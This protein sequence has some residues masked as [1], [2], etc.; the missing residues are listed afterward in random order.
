[1]EKNNKT[2]LTAKK[3]KMIK[4][5]AA[6]VIFVI[7][8]VVAWQVLYNSGTFLKS[9]FPSIP[10]IF[11]ALAKDFTSD[12]HNL[13]MMVLNSMKL[14][15]Q[16][17]GIG[18]A[19]ALVLSGLSMASETVYSVYNMVVS[20]FD[21][22]P[23]VALL[24][25]AILFLGIGQNAI[26]FL[27]IHSVVWPM[28]RNLIDGFK[29]TPVIYIE[30]GKNIGLNRFSLITG[31][32][33]PA[34]FTSILSGLKVGWARAWRGLISAEMI[35]GTT[36][37]LAGVGWFIQYK[38]NFMDTASVYGALVVIIIIG[39]IIEYGVFAPIEKAT[40]RKWGM[41]K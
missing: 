38:R 29:T 20:I 2:P 13:G 1:M 3:K 24:P 12:T 6:R 31:V 4:S 30:A 16:G 17:M 37:S 9:V 25:I 22:L 15:L 26:I 32:Y 23:G 21:L 40:V 19:L 7:A 27:V 33:V 34:S 5:V 18:I 39:L 41:T 11:E 10:Q 14:I 28:S 35:C 8:A 36:Q